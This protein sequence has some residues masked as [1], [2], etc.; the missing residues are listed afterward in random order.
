[1]SPTGILFSQPTADSLA[2]LLSMSSNHGRV[3]DRNR[4]RGLPGGSLS[5]AADQARVSAG[6]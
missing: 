6:R 3:S 5:A 2:I 4:A 1:L